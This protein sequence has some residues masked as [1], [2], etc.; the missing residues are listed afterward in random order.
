MACARATPPVHRL[1]AALLLIGLAAGAAG[2]NRG[3][4]APASYDGGLA[5]SAP[6]A[7]PNLPAD[8][9]GVISYATYQVVVAQDGDTMDMVASRVGTST[10][11]LAQRNALPT[12]YRLREGEVLLLP[13]D[14]ARAS[15]D[16][17]GVDGVTTQPL[18]WSP[19]TA[20][21]AI[22][23]TAAAAQTP[24]AAARPT[25]SSTRCATG[26]NWARPPIPSRGSTACR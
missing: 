4:P 15:V 21:A 10:D 19:E 24:F 6:E 14:V 13:D 25:R 20:A 8:S 7:A 5:V 12:D 11:A 16:G 26:W 17:L 9:R 22:D 3:D 1:P 18:D 23:G 2:C